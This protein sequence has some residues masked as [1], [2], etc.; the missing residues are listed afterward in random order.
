MNTFRLFLLSPL[1]G[2]LLRWTVLF[3]FAWMANAVMRRSHPR[4]RLILWRGVLVI[5]W[6]LPFVG[7]V[8][9]NVFRIDREA[10]LGRALASANAS[11][12]LAVRD[13]HAFPSESSPTLP[14]PEGFPTLKTWTTLIALVWIGGSL[15][16]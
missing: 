16:G 12:L 4:R 9:I 15:A 13:A 10:V 11:A 6:L 8:P 7:S 3:A 2:L 14:A 1:G 5:G